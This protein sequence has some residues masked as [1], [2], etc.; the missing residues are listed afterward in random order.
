MATEHGKKH[1]DEIS[2][3]RHKLDELYRIVEGLDSTVHGGKHGIGISERQLTIEKI[4]NGTPQDIGIAW[5]VKYMWWA[6]GWLVGL[7]T[8]AAAVVFHPILTKLKAFIK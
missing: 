1:E 2:E 7:L 5:K 4:I 8:A 3:L 6:A